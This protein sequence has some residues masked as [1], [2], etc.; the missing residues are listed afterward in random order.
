MKQ[1][2][3][4]HQASINMI[5]NELV[6]PLTVMFRSFLLLLQCILP[7]AFKLKSF[8]SIILLLQLNTHQL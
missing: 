2:S 7:E 8:S 6:L 3:T 5:G 4:V 1:L